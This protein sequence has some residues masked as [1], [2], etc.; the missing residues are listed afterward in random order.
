MVIFINYSYDYKNDDFGKL[1]KNPKVLSNYFL[2]F[3]SNYFF[4]SS[5]LTSTKIFGLTK[6]PGTIDCSLTI[7]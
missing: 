1:K 6:V 5:N 3:L 7:P 4:K 2:I